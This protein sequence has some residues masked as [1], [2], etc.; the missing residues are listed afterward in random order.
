MRNILG[1]WGV[2]RLIATLIVV[3]L[4]ALHISL[5]G[6]PQPTQ[7]HPT[8]KPSL[9]YVIIISEQ[10]SSCRLPPRNETTPSLKETD[11]FG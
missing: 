1:C 5:A 11:A 8:A 7:S 2:G 10:L 4:F 9:S 6:P 3:C